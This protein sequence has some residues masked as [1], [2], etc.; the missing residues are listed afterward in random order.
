MRTL[1]RCGYGRRNCAARDVAVDADA[2]DEAAERIC[3][4]RAEE[5]DDGLIALPARRQVLR[6]VAL[7]SISPAAPPPPVVRSHPRLP[8]YAA[9][10]QPLL[11][12]LALDADRVAHVLRVVQVERRDALQIL[13]E[14]R[15]GTVRITRRL[16][17][18]I[19]VRVGQVPAERQ[20][21]CRWRSR[22]ASSA[23]SPGW[24]LPKMMGGTV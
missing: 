23:R 8:T 15:V 10:D 6:G 22:P 24:K 18:A 17:H 9:F 2:G 13:P 20:A 4:V 14:E 12:Q 11:R 16:Q 3:D 1:R 5:I 21:R 19:D 7:I